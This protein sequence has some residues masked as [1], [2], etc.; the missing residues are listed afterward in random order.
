MPLE[1]SL[2]LA[3]C[4]EINEKDENNIGSSLFFLKNCFFIY[5]ADG[6]FVCLQYLSGVS[7]LCLFICFICLAR[8]VQTIKLDRS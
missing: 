7:G 5:L 8:K 4:G 1:C 3:D 2:R 6:S